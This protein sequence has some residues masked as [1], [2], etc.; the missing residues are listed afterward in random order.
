MM[1]GTKV[2]VIDLT[3][4]HSGREGIIINYKVVDVNSEPGRY[5]PFDREK[6]VVVVQPNG[7]W[8]TMYKNRL[9]EI[10]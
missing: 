6:E 5:K 9:K 10:L 8:F 2:K 7:N 4:I 3:G 1:I